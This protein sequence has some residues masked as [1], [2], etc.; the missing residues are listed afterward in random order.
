MHSRNFW[1]LLNLCHVAEHLCTSRV[2]GVCSVVAWDSEDRLL[3]LR[4]GQIQPPS[5]FLSFSTTDNQ[6]AEF[7]QVS[8]L[9]QRLWGLFRDD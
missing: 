5:S 8:L 2:G 6:Y 9:K 3:L 1:V 4:E 7:M